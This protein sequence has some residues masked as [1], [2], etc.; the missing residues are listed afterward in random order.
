MNKGVRISSLN[1]ITGILFFFA[2]NVNAGVP[3]MRGP[4]ALFFVFLAFALGL[5]F[6]PRT[7]NK[8]N[9]SITLFVANTAIYAA[10]AYPFF[11]YV[12]ETTSV[13]WVVRPL[14]TSE[15][16]RS[17]LTMS[18][19]VLFG[20]VL[21]VF[22]TKRF[23]PPVIIEPLPRNNSSLDNAGALRRD[24]DFKRYKR[25]EL[26]RIRLIQDQLD[27]LFVQNRPDSQ[28]L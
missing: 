12:T 5:V 21:G 4:L 6:L 19:L 25:E 23:Q 9:Q 1:I 2:V 22:I 26:E 14:T 28:R 20:F 16:I 11:Y 7:K 15:F 18:L 17:I 24:L 8:N 27:R 10:L 13:K 3:P